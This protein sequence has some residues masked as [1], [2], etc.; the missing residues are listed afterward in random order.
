[1]TDERWQ[2]VVGHIKDTFQVLE[3]GK[4][5]LEDRP[6]SSEFI[7]FMGPEKKKMK[8]ERITHPVVTGKKTLGSRRIGGTTSVEYEY[9]DTDVVQRIQAWQFDDA[10]Q[11]WQQITSDIFNR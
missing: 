10:Q 2:Q 8:L 7:C 4:N 11:Q 5:P 6:G 9:S 3:E 1:M